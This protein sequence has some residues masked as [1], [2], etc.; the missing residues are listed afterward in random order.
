MRKK[1]R[2][3]ILVL[4]TLFC[5]TSYA[6]DHTLRLESGSI[7]SN[8][9]YFK[10]DADQG[11]RVDLPKK[12]LGFFYR[13]E[14]EWALTK[15][16]SLRF[17][18][19]P[20]TGKYEINPRESINFDNE[21]FIA[22]KKTAVAYRFNS[23]RVGYIYN[24]ISEADYKL[25]IGATGKIREAYIELEN[26]SKSQKYAKVGFVPLFYFGAIYPLSDQVVLNFNADCLAAPQGRAID[27][28]VEAG[29]ILNDQ[30]DLAI[31]GRVVEGGA[32]NEKVKNFALFHF[33]F[34]SLTYKGK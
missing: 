12:N 1:H 20:L 30:F 27:T 8:Y 15:E 6:S 14:G 11:T 13:I 33:Y 4:T 29:Y 26:E 10:I 24:F 7:Q 34:L 22:G 23:Y 32:D 31:G 25:R 3:N 21:I 16:H 2:P 19:A 5:S 17:L 18:Y 9:N 28:M